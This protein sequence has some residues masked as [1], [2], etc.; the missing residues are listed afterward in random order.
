MFLDQLWG[1]LDPILG[2]HPFF[3]PYFHHLR[4]G[5]DHL[6][7][8][9]TIE[10]PKSY[11]SNYLMIGQQHCYC[12][13]FTAVSSRHT[14]TKQIKPRNIIIRLSQYNSTNI[15]KTKKQKILCLRKYIKKKIYHISALIQRYKRCDTKQQW[16]AEYRVIFSE[17]VT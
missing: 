7:V 8:E 12:F 15:S 10:L 11:S 2:C 16:F 5:E 9:C 17:I 3:S 6:C 4:V 1:I 13:L 14:A